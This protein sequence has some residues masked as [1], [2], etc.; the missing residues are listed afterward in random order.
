MKALISNQNLKTK[1]AFI[2][3]KYFRKNNMDNEE[4][5][6]IKTKNYDTLFKG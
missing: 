6:Q 3:E 4:S 5:K 2:R 1:T